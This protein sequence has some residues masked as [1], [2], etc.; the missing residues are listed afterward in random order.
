M[1]QNSAG[2][3]YIFVVTIKNC[4]GFVYR[5]VQVLCTVLAQI[6]H[7]LCTVCSGDDGARQ[8]HGPAA[9]QAVRTDRL[10]TRTITVRGHKRRRRR[11]K[12]SLLTPRNACSRDRILN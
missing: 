2:F 1:Q 7:V 8:V 6:G 3:V 4:A 11:A 5:I 9:G 10:D 12:T